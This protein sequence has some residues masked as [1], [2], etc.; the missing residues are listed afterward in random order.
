MRKIVGWFLLILLAVLMTGFFVIVAGWTT[1]LVSYAVALV[2][3]GIVCV[4]MNLILGK[5]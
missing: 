4:A 1:T 5:V 2:I 3:V